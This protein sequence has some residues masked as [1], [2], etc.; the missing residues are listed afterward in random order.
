MGESSQEMQP[1]SWF[2]EPLP[3]PAAAPRETASVLVPPGVF[4]VSK[5]DMQETASNLNPFFPGN[6]MPFLR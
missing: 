2:Q 6:D 5:K 1:Q 4:K 3:A